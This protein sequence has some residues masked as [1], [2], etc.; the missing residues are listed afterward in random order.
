MPD[1]A[2][3]EISTGKNSQKDSPAGAAD[4]SKTEIISYDPD[5]GIT[6][7]LDPDSAA[8]LSAFP[9]PDDIKADMK[10]ALSR[11]FPS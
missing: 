4:T 1:A 10:N 2:E 7:R 3:E 8:I 11:F 9:V 6:V 5:N